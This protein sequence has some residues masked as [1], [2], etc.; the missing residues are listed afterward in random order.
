MNDTKNR[1]GPMVGET[2]LTLPQ[3]F[4]LRTED[5]RRGRRD[6]EEV[7]ADLYGKLRTP[8]VSYV[9]HLVGTTR[10]AEDLVQVAFI[11]LFDQL[12]H[13]GEID[14]LRGWLYR[15]VHNLAIEHARQHDRRG[16]LLQKWFADRGALTPE[17]VESAEEG[18][19]RREQ[20][21]NALV[22]LN[23]RERHS[24]VLRAEGLSYQEIADVLEI[25]VKSVS[26]YLARGLKKFESK[27]ENN[28]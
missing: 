16:S 1:A 9:Y 18:F 10:D 11:Q 26:V 24:L 4:S 2:V 25:S 6:V 5:I 22:V 13:D 28:N 23:E 15:V 7:V 21:E 27:H 20:I 19:I 8:L 14:N 3:T 17:S 12:E